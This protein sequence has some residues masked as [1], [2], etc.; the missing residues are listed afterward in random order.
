MYV[1]ATLPPSPLPPATRPATDPADPAWQVVLA[2]TPQGEDPQRLAL[3]PLTTP[4]RALLQALDGGSTLRQ[5]VAHAP[6]LG[7]KRLTHDAARLLA[8]GLVRQVQGSLPQ[9]LV[10]EAMNLTLRV[11]AA[12]FLPKPPPPAAPPAVHRPRSAQALLAFAVT[13][14]VSGLLIV[15][16]ASLWLINR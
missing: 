10:I 8:F 13:V 7:S 5:L 11:P 14:F 12:A 3:L 16:L 9:R 1:S 2:R 6:A 4:Q 15:A